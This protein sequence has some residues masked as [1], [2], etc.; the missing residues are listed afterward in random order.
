M[1]TLVN[2]PSLDSVGGVAQI[3]KIL[4][5]NSQDNIDYFIASPKCRTFSKP[6]YLIFRY[7]AFYKSLKN[8]DGVHINPSFRKTALWRDLL[9]LLLAKLRKKKVFVFFHGWD[10]SYEKKINNNKVLK[11]IFLLYNNCDAF[12]LLGNVFKDELLSI[13]IKRNANFFN[14]TSVADDRYINDFSIENRIDNYN[15]KSIFKFLFISRITANKGI[16]FSLRVFDTIRKR[17]PQIDFEF[18]LA[19]S[20]NYLNQIRRFIVNNKISNVKFLGFVENAI[21]HQTLKN[22]DILILTSESEG[23]PNTILEGMLYGLPIITADVGAISN[24][25]KTDENGLISKG[26]ELEVY[27]SYIEKLLNSENLYKN[28]AANNHKIAINNFTKDKVKQKLL[29]IYE[30]IYASSR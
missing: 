27:V 4:E 3:Y 16:E 12:I 5:L 22:S 2:I 25:V 29:L 26:F 21:K 1:R 11:Y 9:Y 6:L 20:G 13:G 19:G 10:L 24:W 30:K 18:I 15:K 17:N 14:V 28:I 7:L 23:L 8:Y